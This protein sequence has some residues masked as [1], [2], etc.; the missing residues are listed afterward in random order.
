M[1]KGRFEFDGSMM[2]IRGVKREDAASY[3]LKA[4]NAVGTNNFNINLNVTFSAR[5]A[6]L[7]LSN[8]L[9]S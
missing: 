3:T 1:H 6:C 5:W 4:E 7:T 9:K 8:C 2:L